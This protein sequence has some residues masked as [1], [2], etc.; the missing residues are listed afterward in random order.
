[1]QIHLKNEITMDDQ[2]EVL[3]QVYPVDVTIKQ[4][5][6]Y[7]VFTNEESEKVVIKAQ[8]SELM[9]T[10]FA[11][12]NAVMRFLPNQ[13]AIVTIPTP[14]GLQHFVT[15]TSRYEWNRKA[16]S[17]QLDYVLK[18]LEGDQILADYRMIITWG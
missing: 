15:V 6:L 11:N 3:D 9:M 8:S 7:L 12:P 13:E 1:M 16:Q 10:R 17:I 2:I 14:M 18:P 4:D 5:Q